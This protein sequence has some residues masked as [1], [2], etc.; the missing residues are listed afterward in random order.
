M[1]GV[2]FVQLLGCQTDC[3]KTR[4]GQLEGRR[5]YEHYL[6][7]VTFIPVLAALESVALESPTP[8]R[9]R[10]RDRRQAGSVSTKILR[11]FGNTR[12]VKRYRL[13]TAIGWLMTN[14]SIQG[15]EPC[16]RVA[17]STR[18]S[19]LL[20]SHEKRKERMTSRARKS[21]DFLMVMSLPANAA[22]GCGGGSAV[23][24]QQYS[25]NSS[26]ETERRIR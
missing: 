19:Q 8:A 26:H 16:C 9:A 22:A 15:A 1:T 23:R 4:A 7:C 25:R 13:L 6:G 20:P 24:I 17:R 14:Q 12:S 11:Q 3:Q 10:G 21:R 2:R 5:A 18:S